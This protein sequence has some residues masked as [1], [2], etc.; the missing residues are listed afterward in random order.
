MEKF[1]KNQID[2][3]LQIDKEV[4]FSADYSEGFTTGDLQGDDR[5]ISAL[6]LS[7][8]FLFAK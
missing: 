6:T 3:L 4:D 2:Q 1:T 5:T 8:S 7:T